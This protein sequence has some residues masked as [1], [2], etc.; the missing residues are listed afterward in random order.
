VGR[1]LDEPD[2]GEEDPDRD[3][4]DAHGARHPGGER[5]PGDDGDE[6]REGEEEVLEEVL[7]GGVRAGPRHRER[8]ERDERREWDPDLPGERQRRS[9]GLAQ[10]SPGECEPCGGDE[11]VEGQQ[12]PDLAAV[13]ET[14][15][16][17]VR[18]A[19]VERHPERRRDQDHERYELGPAHEHDCD[20]RRDAQPGEPERA[21]GE[22][23]AGRPVD[24]EHGLGDRDQGDPGE[25]RDAT[26]GGKD[27]RR[28]ERA[29]DSRE[30]GHG[31]A[32]TNVR[33]AATTVLMPPGRV[34]TATR[35][36]GTASRATR[37]AAVRRSY[38][39]GCRP[40]G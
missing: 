30:V 31:C 37:P 15:E 28:S 11:A 25:D 33:L 26:P 20:D 1:H 3:S 10:Q 18:R 5:R 32:D 36:V 24:G 27:E 40:Y 19:E 4:G 12:P 6:E 2:R 17:A 16:E 38:R 39:G 7:G 21:V 22:R 8:R 14:D 13:R 35:R 34:A 9:S 23:D 29:E